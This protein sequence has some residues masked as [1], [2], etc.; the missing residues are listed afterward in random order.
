MIPFRLMWPTIHLTHKCANS[1]LPHGQLKSQGWV[2]SKKKHDFLVI[3]YWVGGWVFHTLWL[4]GSPQINM[5]IGD[6]SAKE[7][8]SLYSPSGKSFMWFFVL[9]CV[10]VKLPSPFKVMT[11]FWL[12]RRFWAEEIL[13]RETWRK[14]SM[15]RWSLCRCH[16]RN[17]YHFAD[18]W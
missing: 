7:I 18:I 8:L 9:P 3:K 6:I 2:A 16:V 13:G 4:M 15:L 14:G 10:I 11:T 5:S 12:L 1:S 17:F